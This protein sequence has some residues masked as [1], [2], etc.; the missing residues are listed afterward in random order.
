MNFMIFFPS[1]VTLHLTSS[2]PLFLSFPFLSIVSSLGE[3]FIIIQFHGLPL[4]PSFS[5]VRSS[6]HSIIFSFLFFV[7]PFLNVIAE[8]NIFV[9]S[10]FPL[11]HHYLISSFLQFFI[12]FLC[13]T[14]SS[15]LYFVSPFLHFF[16]SFPF[17]TISPSSLVSFQRQIA[18]STTDA[19]LSSWE[20]LAL[21]K[22]GARGRN[23]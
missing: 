12:S 1:E 21:S 19:F 10:F 15:F 20:Q 17:F 7:S 23:R 16:I 11:F 9:S 18:R 6:I 3:T 22:G 5:T 13:F 14:I 8:Y 4:L 2:I